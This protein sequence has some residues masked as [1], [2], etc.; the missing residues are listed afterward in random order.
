[1]EAHDHSV[2][3]HR[4]DLVTCDDIVDTLCGHFKIIF[5]EA[6]LLTGI[7][8]SGYHLRKK[9]KQQFKNNFNNNK[10]HFPFTQFIWKLRMPLSES[11]QIIVDTLRDGWGVKW[12]WIDSLVFL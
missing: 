8:Q 6:T 2:R 9:E 4:S 11:F 1:M 10:K 3:A 12:V 7:L 5:W